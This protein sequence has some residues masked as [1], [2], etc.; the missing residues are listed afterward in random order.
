MAG[1]VVDAQQNGFSGRG[2]GLQWCGHLRWVKGRDARICDAG[3]EQ[4]G[5]IRGT[6]FHRLI[7][8][9]HFER[10]V[11]GGVGDGAP[12]GF[13]YC[14][15]VV[16]AIAD[17]ARHSKAGITRVVFILSSSFFGESGGLPHPQFSG[18][19][20]SGFT[21]IRT[22]VNTPE[23]ENHQRHQVSRKIQYQGFPSCAFVAFVVDGLATFP[24]PSSATERF[25]SIRC[26]RPSSLVV[27]PRLIRS[28]TCAGVNDG[29]SANSLAARLTTFGDASDVPDSWSLLPPGT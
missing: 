22:R 7:T 5:G 15:H 6:I 2:G 26:R 19:Q 16:C 17:A 9:D 20:P 4:H 28:M 10:L 8:V 14:A 24:S 23:P 3:G 29:R 18:H 12:L 21:T 1:V 25:S 27:E 13:L 11:T